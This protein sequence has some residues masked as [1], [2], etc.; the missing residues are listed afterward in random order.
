M[1]VTQCTQGSE[2]KVVV[3]NLKSH[4]FFNYFPNKN[5]LG[6]KYEQPC[7]RAEQLHCIKLILNSIKDT[8]P[9]LW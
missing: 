5:L 4:K 3:L 8:S 1:S 2:A 9:L 7:Y 6:H